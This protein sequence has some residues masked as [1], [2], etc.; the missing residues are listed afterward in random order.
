MKE[1]AS[2]D[3]CAMD[4]LS[5]V[6]YGVVLLHEKGGRACQVTVPTA[7]YHEALVQAEQSGH[8]KPVYPGPGLFMPTAWG[9]VY[10]LADDRLGKDA[11]VLDAV[12]GDYVLLRNM[13]L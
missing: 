4:I 12:T 2:W 9:W 1:V 5:A 6:R 7:T 13:V 3:C 11:T 10:M 8:I